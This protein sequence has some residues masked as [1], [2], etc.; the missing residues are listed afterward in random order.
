M[1]VQSGSTI[2]SSFIEDEC[3]IGFKSIIL[4]GSRLER[5]CVIG[6]NSVVPP[7]RIIPSY[8]LWAGNP[9]E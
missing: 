7:G 9:V 6:P 4:E 3:L 5:G 1:V 8:Q 2:Y